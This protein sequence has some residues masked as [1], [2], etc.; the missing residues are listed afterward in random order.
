MNK[1][2]IGIIIGMIIGGLMGYF[3]SGLI[4]KPKSE[5]T[6]NQDFQIDEN[7]KEEV[8]SFFGSNPTNEEVEKYCQENRMYCMYYCMEI[9]QND[10]VCE[11]IQ[12][13]QNM[14]K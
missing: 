12:L 5:F 10:D 3:L 7:T 8:I 4:I 1:L 14:K 11:K 2:F 6:R 13:P 9:N